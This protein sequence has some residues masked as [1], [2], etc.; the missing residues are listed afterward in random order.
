MDIQNKLG[1]GESSKN[2]IEVKV[3]KR[4]SNPFMCVCVFENF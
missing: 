4:L 1:R 3:K 2:E